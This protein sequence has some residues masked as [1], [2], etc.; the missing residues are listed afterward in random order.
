MSNLLL[1]SPITLSQKYTEQ[2]EY[3]KKKTDSIVS[4]VEMRIRRFLTKEEEDVV[5]MAIMLERMCGYNEVISDEEKD[6][7]YF[8]FRL[9][10]EAHTK[11]QLE[12]SFSSKPPW[13][14]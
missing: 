12:Q 7:Y 14:V 1:N 3:Q 13:S 11:E 6:K 4:M 2:Q 8:N 5:R 10:R 9:E